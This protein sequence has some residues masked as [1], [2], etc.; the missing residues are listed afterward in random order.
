MKIEEAKQL[1]LKDLVCWK[2]DRSDYGVVV[3]KNS[4]RITIN[5]LNGACK[6]GNHR[7]AYALLTDPENPGAV[8]SL[9]LSLWEN[10]NK[11]QVRGV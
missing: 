2:E 5:W 3:A 4:D 6:C 8:T 9:A 10:I 11:V 1:E 7:V